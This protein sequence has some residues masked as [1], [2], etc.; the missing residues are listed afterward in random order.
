MGRRAAASTATMSMLDTSIHDP[1]FARL[2]VEAD[3][4]DLMWRLLDCGDA[5]VT[6]A[7]LYLTEHAANKAV[8]ADRVVAALV[9]AAKV[10]QAMEETNAGEFDLE[11]AGGFAHVEALAA[12]IKASGA[13]AE[14][15]WF[16][17]LE[18]INDGTMD[19]APIN[20]AETVE[21]ADLIAKEKTGR[22]P[23]FQ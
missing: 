15:A 20:E 21:H 14:Q 18:I 1:V 10:Y 3:R 19:R 16:D 17:M 8:P 22:A 12:E 13:D 2:G 23:D 5:F 9:T 4:C 6:A 11:N 7:K